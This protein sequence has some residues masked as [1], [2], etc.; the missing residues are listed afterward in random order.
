MNYQ[1][2]LVNYEINLWVFLR[3]NHTIALLYFIFLLV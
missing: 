2:P 3:K 1:P